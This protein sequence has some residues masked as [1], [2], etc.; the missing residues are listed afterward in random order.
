MLKDKQKFEMSR[1][2]YIESGRKLADE[3]KNKALMWK[4][5]KPCKSKLH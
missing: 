5:S 2:R 1:D 4:T 3:K